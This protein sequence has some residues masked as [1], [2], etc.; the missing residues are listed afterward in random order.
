M[1]KVPQPQRTETLV[2]PLRQ[3]VSSLEHSQPTGGEEDGEDAQYDGGGGRVGGKMEHST[4]NDDAADG[5]RDAHEWRVEGG[6]VLASTEVKDT[7][8]IIGAVA[9][10][11]ATINIVGGFMVTRRMLRMFNK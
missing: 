6:L 3:P 5:V 9:I 7:P 10:L 4:E 11:F 2:P 1:P 8:A